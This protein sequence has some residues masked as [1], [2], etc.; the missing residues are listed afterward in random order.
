MKVLKSVSGLSSF[1]IASVF[2]L[3]SSLL[4]IQ[5]NAQA[6]VHARSVDMTPVLASVSGILHGLRG[7]HLLA[8]GRLQLQN[9]QG[10]ITVVRL[11]TP[12]LSELTKLSERLNQ[13]ELNESPETATCR[14]LPP[15]GLPNLR[16]GPNRTLVLTGTD[17]SV[18]RK[19]EPKLAEDQAAAFELRMALTALALN[20]L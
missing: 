9:L 7:A 12:A 8:D 3:A 14:M 6:T 1:V 18:A 16:V 2:I 19:V 10:D 20:A 4:P 11:T 13:I 15:P 5:A 17:C